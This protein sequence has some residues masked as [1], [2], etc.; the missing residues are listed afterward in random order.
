M[1]SYR[2]LVLVSAFGLCQAMVDVSQ[3]DEL[4]SCL[5]R[6][7]DDTSTFSQQE[8]LSLCS[9]YYMQ[10]NWKSADV[11][12]PKIS[13]LATMSPQEY[14][15]SLID[16]FT[17]EARNPQ[18]RRVRKEYRMMTNE[19]RDNYHRAIVMLK[20]DTTVLP[21]KFEII[22]DLHAGSVTNSA[23]G[24][25]GFLPWHRIYM[26]IWEEGLRE[27]V[28]TVVVPYWDVT[29]DSAMDDPRRSIVWSPQF[30][31]NG[32]GLVTVGP[33]ADWTTGYGPLHRNYAVF[34]HLLTRANIQTVFTERTI[35]EIS[36]LTAND[37]RYVFEL[38]HNNIHDWIGGTVSVQAWASFD[39][40]FMLIHGYV[41]YIWY[42]FQEMQ[43]E[44]G[45]IDISVDY[46]FTANHQILNGTAFDGEEPVGL[47][48][49]MT[50]REAV[51][52]GVV[53]MNLMNYEEAQSDCDQ[54]TPCPPNYECVDGFCA[55][56]AVDNDVCNQI[57][58]LQNNFCINK[59][60]DVSLFSFLAVEII[61]ERMENI[62]NMGN[63]PVR[64]WLADK[65]A[66]IY[67]VSASVIH[68]GKYSNS[69]SDMCGR[70]GGCCKPV[71]RVNIQVSGNDGDLWL[72]RESAFVDAR[73]AVSHSQMFVAVRRV[74]IGRFLIF[75]ADE[76]GNLCDAYLVDTFGNRILLRRSEG[77]IISEDDPRLSNTLAE[78]ESKM[79]DY[80]NG[81]DLPPNVLQ[82][83]YVLSFHC[84]ADRN[85][86]PS[87]RNGNKK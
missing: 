46:P 61:H 50:N 41:D 36:Q 8:Q 33:F 58:P 17:A 42:R 81:Q 45:G 76:Y 1:E 4:Q 32:H 49:G 11:S 86:G 31:G 72:Y 2:L 65:T 71:E 14:I 80:Q 67:R 10:K 13:T 84:R 73:L 35:A 59:E 85:L 77:I 20:Q 68:Q 15:Q 64:Q 79:F 34:T 6:F 23:H 39:P 69:L 12:K 9:K 27:Q 37:Q 78:A 83:Q 55:S 52:E 48:P 7:A 18:G 28:P 25:P 66:D 40:A 30:Q 54:Q 70:P 62:C 22:A 19:E 47:I 75:A 3:S 63:F 24:G 38:Y 29:R 21:N 56:R 43:L 26:M 87:V 5:D 44:L 74:P 82:N 60:C 53:Y 57:Q 51:A 16:R